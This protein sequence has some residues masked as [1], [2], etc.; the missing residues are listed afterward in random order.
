MNPQDEKT[1]KSLVVSPV[2]EAKV[3]ST[4][5]VSTTTPGSAPPSRK[6][7]GGT[8][9]LIFNQEFLFD[10]VTDVV[11]TEA[12]QE[13]GS[14]GP[15]W[16]WLVECDLVSRLY[17]FMIN[18]GIPVRGLRVN[19]C[20]RATL[21]RPNTDLHF[22]FD[23]QD[24]HIEVVYAR[25]SQGQKTS[26]QGINGDL[27]WLLNGWH[28][29]VVLF[30]AHNQPDYGSPGATTMYDV[31]QMS[32]VEPRELFNDL[33]VHLDHSMYYH[34]AHSVPCGN[35]LSRPQYRVIEYNKIQIERALSTQYDCYLSAVI[36]SSMGPGSV[37]SDYIARRTEERLEMEYQRE[38][39][40]RKRM[41][42]PPP[43]PRKGDRHV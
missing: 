38:V 29:H 7:A 3:L 2:L 16:D 42:L 39:E 40:E 41:G 30:S 24:E 10:C 11:R 26:A 27:L 25:E 13:G 35:H 17:H 37:A 6:P 5:C 21:R 4:P 14:R 23:G 19:T 28:R 15:G 22:H 20:S 9:N 8:T 33:E 32:Q 18:R 1:P 12:R 43:R 36:W 34:S 31:L